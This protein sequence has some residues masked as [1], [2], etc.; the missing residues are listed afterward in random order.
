LALM[1]VFTAANMLVLGWLGL[2]GVGELQHDMTSGMRAP[3]LL[4]QAVDT[5]RAV[6]VHLKRQ[7][8]EWKDLLLRGQDREQYVH[9]FDNFSREESTVQAKLAELK[10]LTTKL[11]FV[12]PDLD[13]LQ[14][15]HVVLG[16]RYREALQRFDAKDVNSAH[17]VDR[18]VKGMDR[19]PT[20]ALEAMVARIQQLSQDQIQAQENHATQ[21]YRTIRT[22]EIT[23]LIIS[24][25]LVVLFSARLM[26]SITV[27]LALAVQAANDLAAGDLTRT[28]ESHGTDEPGRLLDAMGRMIA[29]LSKVITEVRLGANALASAS[30]QV[31]STAQSLS[32]GTSEQAASVE[33]T[34]TNLEQMSASITQNAENSRKTQG[35]AADGAAAAEQSGA[36]VNET[37]LAMRQIAEKIGIVEEIA[38][39]TNLLALNAAIEAAR[40]GE[41]GKGFAVVA[42][43]V[44]RLSERSQAAAKSIAQVASSS[45]SIA[46]RSG[47]LIG[48]LVPAI[49]QTASLVQE[50]AAASREQAAGVSQI[51]GAMSQVD[52]A[53]QRNASAAEELSSTAEELSG[54]AEALRQLMASFRT[55]D[56][57]DRK[58]DVGRKSG[59]RRAEKPVRHETAYPVARLEAAPRP[60]QTNGH[61][62]FEPF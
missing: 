55:T 21:T 3:R 49:R 22:T 34:S 25:V 24:F 7:V 52:Q 1:A 31:S 26:R 36:A 12:V 6:Q 27:P 15:A 35:I 46:E 8:Q 38:Y 17:V 16:G 40:A 62:G 43:E 4:I 61:G 41:H 28:I 23:I 58:A 51:N 56:D 50:V 11:D 29:S 54:Q 32:Q 14:R 60:A 20:D 13:R 37:I 47:K 9:Y 57:G 18:L 19:E 59:P 39:Q 48:E 30:E 42:A 5:A 10:E 53:T 45:V 44:R 2:S 33:E